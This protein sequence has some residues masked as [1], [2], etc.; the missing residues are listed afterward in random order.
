MVWLR[1]PSQHFVINVT[2]TCFSFGVLKDLFTNFFIIG[3]FSTL[4][5]FNSGNSPNETSS[6]QKLLRLCKC[7]ST[8]VSSFLNTNT[9]SF[10]RLASRTSEVP[11]TCRTWTIFAHLY[12]VSLCREQRFSA[13]E[14]GNNFS[15]LPQPMISSDVRFFN[16][17]I[18]SLSWILGKSLSSSACNSG[19]TIAFPCSTIWLPKEFY[20][21]YYHVIN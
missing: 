14:M 1:S 2:W 17:R 20:A 7:L 8:S 3:T 5:I 4:T 9:C 6:S 21:T 10:V 11:D 19:R 13:T 12:I 16:S 18:W 15:I